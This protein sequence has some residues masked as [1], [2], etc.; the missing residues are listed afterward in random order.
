MLVA[1]R[2]RDWIGTWR[3]S[4]DFL[5]DRDAFV[6]LTILPLF[7]GACLE[8]NTEV[9]DSETLGLRSRG[10]GLYSLDRRGRLVASTW[11]TLTGFALVEESPDEPDVLAVEG[12]MPGNRRLRFTLLREAEQITFAVGIV[13]GYEAGCE[14]RRS[15][16]VLKRSR[17]PYAEPISQE[18]RH[19]G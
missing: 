15:A 11:G 16:G 5:D 17:G 6:I 14:N 2:F 9:L 8:L 7:E 1:D 19:E 13:E 10:Y 18:V 12:P 3:G 4:V